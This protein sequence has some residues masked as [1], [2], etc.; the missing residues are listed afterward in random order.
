MA[1]DPGSG[2]FNRWASTYER[3]WMQRVIFGPTQ[4]AVLDLAATEVGQPTAILD[5]GCG[6]GR[7]LR[8]AERRFPGTEL[9]GV[10]AAVEM[11]RYAN[12]NLS[13]GSHIHFQ[14]ATAEALPYADAHFDMVF[15]TLTFHH[16]GDQRRAATEVARVL[17][18]A[19]RWL[20]ADFIATGLVRH[21]RGLVRLGHFPVRSEL[22][23]LLADA[24]LV[25]VAERRVPR[26]GGQLSALAIAA[27]PQPADGDGQTS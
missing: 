6:T 9:E 13:E 8:S 15:S 7:L 2:H 10:D 5:I 18:P 16:W 27:L 12:A 1:S 21:V 22:D 23:A 4:A 24:G 25:V 14:H 20:L 19:G 3:S 11:L 17:A 26:L